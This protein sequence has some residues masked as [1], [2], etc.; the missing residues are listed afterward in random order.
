LPGIHTEPGTDDLRPPSFAR[1][2]RDHSVS[3]NT[4]EDGNHRC[5]VGPYEPEGHLRI[6]QDI[7]VVQGKG[8]GQP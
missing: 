2:I 4:A 1:G 3:G 5:I 8:S 7:A 6:R